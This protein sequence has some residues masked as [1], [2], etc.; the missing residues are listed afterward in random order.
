MGLVRKD[1]FDDMGY[2]VDPRDGPAREKSGVVIQVSKNKDVPAYVW[3]H[4][5]QQKLESY[6]EEDIGELEYGDPSLQG[7]GKLEDFEFIMDELLSKQVQGLPDE[8]DRVIRDYEE[9]QLEEFEV[10]EVKT[11]L[12]ERWDVESV[13]T[14]H[15]DTENHPSVIHDEPVIR[16][17]R[18]TGLPIGPKLNKRAL[19]RLAERQRRKELAEKRAA[20]L[21]EE[22]EDEEEDE[23]D[24]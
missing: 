24:D 20:G 21:L 13:T 23:E 10:I 8:K 15:T 4:L 7:Y 9:D 1:E 12:R 22:E 6:G 16:I 14:M 17:S 19:K 2:K 3:E 5:F 18:K 11:K